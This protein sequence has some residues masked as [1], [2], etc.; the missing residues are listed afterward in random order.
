MKLK[1]EHTKL[2]GL[3]TEATFQDAFAKAKKGDVMIVKTGGQIYKS[4]IINKFSNQLTFQWEGEYYLI[5]SNSFDGK[6]LTTSRLVIGDD[7]KTKRTTKG[8]TIKGVYSIII[9]RGDQIVSG[10]TPETGRP[11]DQQKSQEKAQDE[12]ESRHEDIFSVFKE[13]NEGDVIEIT[14]GKVIRKGVDKGSLAKNSITTIKLKSEGISG[15]W[16]KMSPVSFTGA[17]GSKYSKYSN[18]YFF[19]DAGSIR[20]T[21]D[22]ITL[23]PAIKDLNSGNMDKIYIDNVFGVDNIGQHTEDPQY[24]IDD[25]MKSPAMRRAMFKNPSLLDK[26]LGKHKATGIVPLKQ[27]LASLG[28]TNR[29]QRGK[30][31]KFRYSGI[32]I[33]PDYRFNFK[34][35]KVYVGKFTKD[36]VIKRTADNRR[37]SMYITLG[38][39]NDDG[40]HNVTIDFVKL[41]NNEPQREQ[42]G[43]GKINIIELTN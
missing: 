4:E 37:E 29:P 10:V 22:G 25:I 11:K 8:P 12:F 5:T 17:E 26:I 42:V 34:D 30:K 41:V 3:I 1:V 36:N 24:S 7:N 38:T 2:K 14:T 18:S 35:K 9:K 33:R 43:K 31:V 39:K 6:N 28:L 40:T 16:I 20:T 13:L 32:D 27:K 23:I 21:K 15:K 19:F